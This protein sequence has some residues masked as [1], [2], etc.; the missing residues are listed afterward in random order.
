MTTYARSTSRAV[1]LRLDSASSSN[2]RVQFE[3]LKKKAFELEQKNKLDQAIAT[4]REILEVFESGIEPNIDVGLY[5]RVACLLIRQA[6]M[7]EAVAMFERAVD[8]YIEGGFFNKAIALCNKILRTTPD[9]ASIY[10]KLGKMSAANGFM[11]D[12]R[13]NFLEYADRMQK[14]G[15]VDE[16]FRALMEF[17]DIAKD[18]DD[19]RLM[20][21]ERLTQANRMAEALEQLQALYVRYDSVG[22]TADALAVAE[23]MRAI[24]WTVTPRAAVAPSAEAPSRTLVFLEVGAPLAEKPRGGLVFIDVDAPDSVPARPGVRSPSGP[25]LSLSA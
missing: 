15:K 9:R 7:P 18:Q 6:N 20:L 16:A 22:R 3:A 8:L 4:Y 21:V 13:Q 5:N 17:A 1:G 10:Y 23:R 2:W 12:A 11:S 14:S 24:D 25:V 19:I